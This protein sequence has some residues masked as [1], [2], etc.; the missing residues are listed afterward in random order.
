MDFSGKNGFFWKKWIFLE[1][2]DFSG[3][4]L[5]TSTKELTTYLD[6]KCSEIASKT[7]NKTLF[8]F[9]YSV[10]ASIGAMAFFV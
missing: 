10:F 4:R 6:L 8:L 1:K 9:H 2:L 7:K 5:P 3:T